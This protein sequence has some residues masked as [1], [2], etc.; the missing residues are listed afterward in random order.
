MLN[1]I[2]IALTAMLLV[3]LPTAARGAPDPEATQALERA[4][5]AINARDA[6]DLKVSY[7]P[8]GGLEGLFAIAE[9]RVLAARLGG[10]AED[11]DASEGEASPAALSYRVTGTGR[12]NK[13]ADP[14]ELAV[15]RHDGRYEWLDHE[16]EVLRSRPV[17]ARRLSDDSLTL[18]WNLVPDAIFDAPPFKSML[19][20]EELELAE[21]AEIDGTRHTVV[22]APT[23]QQKTRYTYVYLDPDTHLPRRIEVRVEMEIFSGSYRV[24]IDRWKTDVSPS[25]EAFRLEAPEG[26][27]Q[28]RR[29]AAGPDGLLPGDRRRNL[30]RPDRDAAGEAEAE[31][32][33]EPEATRAQPRRRPAPAFALE[34]PAGE[35]VTLESLGGN[36]LVLDFW[37]TW[38][39]PCLKASPEV[40]K[41]HEDYTDEAVRVIGMNFRQA[42]PQKAIDY[43]DEHDYSYGLLLEADQARR[44]YDVNRFPSYVIVD[45]AGRII[46]TVTGY[47][48]GETFE[49]IREIIDE[50]LARM[51]E[52]ASGRAAG[53]D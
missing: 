18:A 32:G 29:A 44:E 24:E 27:R 17:T 3:A 47:K 33:S 53:S 43:M 36:I 34:N 23:D 10:E 48:P 31:D 45:A 39:V 35:T 9:G 1:R 15:V 2:P 16:N 4:A 21:P 26:Y 12:R 14:I 8:R 30:S 22:K 51:G 20:S 40:Q 11:A 49:T 25:P 52:T 7:T 19:A 6:F 37:G 46:R 5:E 28:E 50:E 13:N 41:L 38:C 42:D